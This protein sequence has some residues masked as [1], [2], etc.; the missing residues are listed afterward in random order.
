MRVCCNA[1]QKKKRQMARVTTDSNVGITMIS[2]GISKSVDAMIRMLPISLSA[3]A[4]NLGR[5]IQKAAQG[6]TQSGRYKAGKHSMTAY[7]PDPPPS[8]SVLTARTRA[9]INAV[10]FWPPI[11]SDGAAKLIV[12]FDPSHP[13]KRGK[14]PPAI[15]MSINAK[16]NRNWNI[17][18]LGIGKVNI[19]RI[20]KAKVDEAFTGSLGGMMPDLSGGE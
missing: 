18:A 7:I 13:P 8:Q 3:A 4:N 17:L 19:L 16:R 1:R 6:S 20:L 14:T 9:G 15:Y 5:A 2:D 11:V 12:G 10:H